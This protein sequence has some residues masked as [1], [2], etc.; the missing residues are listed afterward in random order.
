MESWIES[1]IKSKVGE[2]GTKAKLFLQTLV[3]NIPTMML[4]CI[5]LFA[6]VL[7]VLYVRRRRYY[8]EHLVY[9]LHIHTFVYVGVTVIVLLAMALAQWSETARALFS[10]AAGCAM[11]VLVF[12]SIRRVYGEGWFFTTLK[13]LLGGLAYFMVLIVAVGATAFITLLLPE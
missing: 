6:L 10:T 13:F 8:V 5:P 2:Y 1:L 9:A 4:C 11:F 12:L 7:K 3:S